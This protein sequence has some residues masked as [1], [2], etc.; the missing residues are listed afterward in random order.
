MTIRAVL[1]VLVAASAL[2]V[3]TLPAHG[4]SCV[5]AGSE[6]STPLPA[7]L[8]ATELHWTRVTQRTT[9]GND[10]V[11][12]GQVVT[13]DGALGDADVHLWS[14]PGG[15]DW[16][17][18]GTTTSNAD[19]GVFAFGCVLPTVTTDYRVEYHGDVLHAATEATRTV[20]L[21]RFVDD[22]MRRRGGTR[23][24]HTGTVSPDYTGPVLL[25]HRRGEAAWVTVARR[26]TRDSAWRFTVDVAGLRGRHSWRALVPPGDGFTR[27]L[28]TT[29]KIRLA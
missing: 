27:S 17:Y 13:S 5:P 9:Y 20:R 25:Q 26:T 8:T 4:T 29:W 1:A 23:F 10:A 18:Q 22:A 24:A 16:T 2:L 28:G 15:G 19:S 11:I 7:G 3:P 14:R 6:T 12:Q 21:A